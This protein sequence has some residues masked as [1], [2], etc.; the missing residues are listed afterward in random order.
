MLRALQVFVL[1][2]CL[3]SVASAGPLSVGLRAGSTIPDLRDNGGN[4]FSS[5]WSTRVGLLLGVSAEVGITPALSVEA[6]LNYSQQGARKN[7]LQAASLP[8]VPMTLY[9]NFRNTA[10]LDYLEIPVLARFHTGPMRRFFLDLGPYAGL[11]LSAKNVTSGVSPVYVDESGTPFTVPP[12]D[13]E[14]V[15]LVADFGATTDNKSSLHDFNWGLQ[16]GFG[17]EQPVGR[18][19]VSL[20]VRGELGLMNIQ[21]YPAEDGKNSTGALV[22]LLGYKVPLGGL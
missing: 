13:P 18:G 4:D 16:G 5:G 22:I 21:K 14:G 11:L 17:V 15:P 2:C 8:D 3:A 6:E 10:K 12:G 20:E 7:E 19:K 9:A 1:A